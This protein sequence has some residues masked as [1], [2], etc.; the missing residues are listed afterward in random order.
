MAEYLVYHGSFSSG[1]DADDDGLVS[2]KS[3]GTTI[4]IRG[5]ASQVARWARIAEKSSV[6]ASVAFDTPEMVLW[7]FMY[8][9]KF[10]S[11]SYFTD[12]R[13]YDEYH[14]IYDKVKGR[15]VK[16]KVTPRERRSSTD[17]PPR[18]R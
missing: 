3:D 7:R 9:N 8:A 6:I 12:D 5:E 18:R 14:E 4:T 16:V 13:G 11:W 17:A 15:T 1:R 10:N 2:F